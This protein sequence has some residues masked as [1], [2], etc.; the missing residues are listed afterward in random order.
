MR[1]ANPEMLWLLL[2]L[3]GFVLAALWGA[4]R[5]RRAL[6]R[7][8]GG[9][10]YAVRFDRDVSIHLRAAKFLLLLVALAG[11]VLAAARPQWGTR[12][13]PVKRRGV[14]VVIVLDHSLSMA[15]EDLPPSRL[16]RAKEI[17]DALLEELSGDRAALVTFA[18][19]SILLCPLTLDHSAVRLFLETV[20][21]ESM[22]V[23]GTALAEAL[24]L[25]VETFGDEQATGEQER[26]RAIVLLT[27]G[28]DHEGG[29][30]EVLRRLERAGITIF[31][32]GCGTTRGAPIPLQDETGMHSGYK[33]D[34]EGRVV[35]TRLDEALLET[36]ALESEGRYY[37]ATASGVEVEEIVRGLT[38]MDSREFGEVLRARYEERFQLPLVI[39]VLALL[40]E[41]M[42]G[43]RR[44]PAPR[45]R[46]PLG[47]RA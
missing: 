45:R 20:D 31:A 32:V 8:A 16:F 13:E 12:L 34:G 18:G 28:E 26:S 1:F 46:G 41:T 11:V 5:R 17:I 6:E 23:P 25:A 37:R 40:V 47:R 14:D 15:A 44:R 33:K 10:E 30:E 4:A 29:V 36:L 21:A 43:N 42:I 39:A 22:Q 38:G 27:D 19:E 3:P 7:F 35:T 24:R 2:L 9:S